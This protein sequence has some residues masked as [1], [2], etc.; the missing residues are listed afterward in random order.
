MESSPVLIVHGLD[1]SYFTGK[2]EAYLRARGL[3]YRREEMS[4]RSFAALA[5]KTGYRQMPQLQMPDGRWLTDTPLII[6]ALEAQLPPGGSITPRDAAGAFISHLLEDYFDEWL[7]CPALYYRWA[8]AEDARLMSERIARGML[9]DIALPFWLRRSLIL[10]RQRRVYLRG[11][12]VTSQTAP[13]IE[14]LYLSTL[15]ALQSVLV[16]RDFVQAQRPT[17]ADF[18]LFGSMFR[19]FASDPTPAGL[20]RER[21]PAVLAWTARMWALRPAVFA[22]AEHPIGAPLGLE[23]VAAT[24]TGDYLPYCAANLAA[25]SLQAKQ[26][27]FK[28]GR[29][30]MQTPVN[31]YR[32]GRFVS[33][34]QRFQ[35]LEESVRASVTAWLGPSGGAILA[36]PSAAIKHH[37]LPA[38]RDRRGAIIA[39]HP[40]KRIANS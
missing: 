15:D 18:G 19:H 39:H 24:I 37:G 7:W 30:Q 1:L 10:H 34:K 40:S 26:V 14:A 32:A 6:D 2:L 17:R 33:L 8:F 29:A 5:Y 3:A 27:S 16:Q 11:E 31:A 4:T 22:D 9:R 13:A 20:M 21:A 28:I 12:G 36:V 38:L 23:P 35:A 25:C